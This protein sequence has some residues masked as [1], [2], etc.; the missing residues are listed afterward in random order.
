VPVNGGR[1]GP[2]PLSKLAHMQTFQAFRIEQFDRGD[3]DL[4]KAQRPA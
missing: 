1:R 2:K 4:L 3:Q